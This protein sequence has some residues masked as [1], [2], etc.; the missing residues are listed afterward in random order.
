MAKK[1][2]VKETREREK[3]SANA[4]WNNQRQNWSLVSRKVK[5]KGYQQEENY[6]PPPS[7]ERLI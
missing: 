1:T 2:S 5:K 7:L 4:L 3:I 6:K